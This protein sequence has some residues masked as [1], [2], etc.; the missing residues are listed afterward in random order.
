MS[1]RSVLITGANRGIGLQLVHAYASLPNCGLILATCRDRGAS[2]D[3]LA[4]ADAS[5]GKVVVLDLDVT[6]HAAYPA[7]VEKVGAMV[8]DAGLNLLINNAGYLPRNLSLDIVTPDDMRRAFEVNCVAP[9][10]L[11]RA[12]LPLIQRA[13]DAGK[14]APVGV[15]RAAIIHVSTSVASVAENASGSATG[16]Y[17]YRCSKSALNQMMKTMSV[18]L[19]ASGIL[20]MSMHPG[21]VQ[22]DMG[23][24]NALITAETSA[25]TMMESLAKLGA[26]DQGAFRRYDNTPIPW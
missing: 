22:T 15:S 2:K 17:A 11:A 9:M 4:F 7:F 8:G 5:A 24:P 19:A 10:F 3:L 18:D 12:L 1:P 14:T 25:R 21:W 16:G 23:G 13:A 26:D 6:D 20:I